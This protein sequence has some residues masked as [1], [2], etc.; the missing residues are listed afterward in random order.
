M[1]LKQEPVDAKVLQRYIKENSDFEF[2]LRVYN[3]IS[4]MKLTCSHGGY[5][6]DFITKLSREYDIR[7]CSTEGNTQCDITLECK[8]IKENFPIVAHCVPRRLEESFHQ[9]LIH[10][11]GP[12]FKRKSHDIIELQ[13]YKGP[14]RIA[15]TKYPKTPYRSEDLVAK[16]ICQ[17]GVNK[18]DNK[19]VSN[20]TD[21][22]PKI[23]QCL[24]SMYELFDFAGT[25]TEKDKIHAFLPVFVIPDGRLWQIAHDET[26][27]LT[28]APKQI[29]HISYYVNQ[30]WEIPYQDTYWAA[31]YLSHIEIVTESAVEKII[32]E[33]ISLD[34]EGSLFQMGIGDGS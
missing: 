24:N 2:E 16:S 31:I 25:H 32:K 28:K 26:G 21:F 3:R 6:T 29:E 19:I 17:V 1:K 7:A 27:K 18:S 11:E 13:A 12:F 34:G 9:L 33:R 30:R 14:C 5:Y 4:S 23:Q 15:Q 10:V 22:Y 20:G 8:N